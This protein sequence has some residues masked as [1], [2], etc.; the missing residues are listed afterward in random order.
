MNKSFDAYNHSMD[1]LHFTP[2]QKRQIAERAARAALQ[3]TAAPKRRPLRRIAVLSAAAV[4]VLAVGTAGAAGVLPNPADVFSGIFGGSPAQTEVINHIG[5]P[6]QASATDHG[7]TISAEAVMGDP[8]NVCVIYRIARTDG[9]PVLPD[10]VT[11]QMFSPSFGGTD[12][13]VLGGLYGSAYCTENEDGSLNYVETRSSDVSL[14][15]TT[16]TA[17]FTDLCYLDTDTNEQVP[18]V[19]GHWKF[20]FSVD[21]EEEYQTLGQDETFQQDGLT[22]TVHEV[23]VSPIAVQV[24]YSADQSIQWSDAPSGR[25][26]N[27]NRRQIERYLENIQILLT[28]TDGTVLDLSNSGGSIAPEDGYSDCTKGD[29]LP[30]IVPMDEIASVTVGDVVYPLN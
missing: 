10:G 15:H 25:Q 19:K 12:F 20:R 6:I 27:T 17:D 26:D 3:Q 29:L 7:V 21:Y 14:N 24:R 5:H 16:A 13:S 11:A 2:E 8:Y 23:T 4:L 30:E 28:K 22:F 18:V 9:Q 1:A